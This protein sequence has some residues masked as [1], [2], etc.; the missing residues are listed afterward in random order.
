MP[1]HVTNIRV[2]RNADETAGRFG[3]MNQENASKISLIF[4]FTSLIANDH[5]HL[6]NKEN[7][8]LKMT[9]E[10]HFH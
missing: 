9:Y 1:L 4:I 8:Y 6:H 5:H 2:S 3:F 7:G 10:I